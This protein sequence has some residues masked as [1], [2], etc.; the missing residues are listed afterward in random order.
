MPASETVVQS[1]SHVKIVFSEVMSK[2][3]IESSTSMST[4]TIT[5]ATWYAS[6]NTLDLAVKDVTLDQTCIVTVNAS[7]AR[8]LSGNL[9][10]GDK[11]GKAGGDYS[12]SFYVTLQTPAKLSVTVLDRQNNPIVGANVSLYQGGKELKRLQ[13]N[14]QGMVEFTS[15]MPGTYSIKAEKSGYDSQS[16]EVTLSFGD[17]KSETFKLAK[18]GEIEAEVAAQNAWILWVILI[19]V[20]LAV[21]LLAFMLLRRR[22]KKECPSCGTLILEKSNL[23]SHCGYDFIRKSR[24]PITLEKDAE[25]KGRRPR[26]FRD[27]RR[28]EAQ[29][30]RPKAESKPAERP[31]VKQAAA[32]L[33]A[34]AA[35]SEKKDIEKSEEERPASKEE[36][37]TETEEPKPAEKPEVESETRKRA[38][39]KLRKRREHRQQEDEKKE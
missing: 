33:T 30:P 5:K 18:P 29:P 38:L 17:S 1:V 27:S 25:K 22:G 20:A 37:P 11:D 14:P 15:L 3:D 24:L 28:P 39:E 6:N 16:K 10:D 9:L 32:P 19:A 2:P 4:G 26:R 12:F 8:D 23:C 35:A 31:A 36:K 34:A 7:K 13:T 21:I